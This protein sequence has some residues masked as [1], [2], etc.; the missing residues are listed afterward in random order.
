MGKSVDITHP[1]IHAYL[2]RVRPAS[3]PILREMER[4]AERRGFPCLGAQCSRLL[5]LLVRASNA[6]RI[7]ELGSG[8][9]YTMYWMAKAL[10]PG[11]KII[12]TEGDP[13]NVE[14]A[15]DY[16]RRGKLTAKTDIR[17]GDAMSIFGKER[18]PFDLIFCDINKHEYPDVIP[19]A[20]RKLRR[21]GLLVADNILRDGRVLDQ[22]VQDEGTRGVRTFTR[23]LYADPGFF[24]TIV[25]IRDGMLI[26]V[27]V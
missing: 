7:F 5:H 11:G 8:F 2:E 6:K 24:T 19:L 13:H 9:G 18:G 14:Q 22:S 10:P 27:K 23:R 25:P 21:G 1:L 16:F 4:E 26:S 17:C 3:D 15:R 12:G 20:K